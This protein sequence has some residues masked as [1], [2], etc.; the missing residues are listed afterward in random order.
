MALPGAATLAR[1]LRP[2]QWTK[3]VGVYAPL[4]FA[5]AVLVEGA[6]LRATVAVVS[7]CLLSSGSYVLND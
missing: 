1:A 4:L 2:R 3:N 6:A 5:R 7:F